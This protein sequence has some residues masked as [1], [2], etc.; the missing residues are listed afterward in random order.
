MN[1]HTPK[2]E[3][4]ASDRRNIR[5][6]GTLAVISGAIAAGAILG[7]DPQLTADA[8]IGAVTCGAGTVAALIDCRPWQAAPPITPPNQG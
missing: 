2:A 1:E 6:L 7:R 3:A 4:R 5:G 8:M